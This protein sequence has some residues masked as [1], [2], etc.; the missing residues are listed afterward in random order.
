MR[1]RGN[2]GISMCVGA[3]G[4]GSMYQELLDQMA[5]V[6][7]GLTTLAASRQKAVMSNQCAAVPAVRRS[8]DSG[9]NPGI[10]DRDS[11]EQIT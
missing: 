10:V 9:S 6:P 2:G 5:T 4:N 1:I 3:K 11:E 7:P 8:T